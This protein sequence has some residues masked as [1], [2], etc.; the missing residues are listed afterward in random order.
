[1]YF[2]S[3]IYL[4][5]INVVTFFRFVSSARQENI[6]PFNTHD[7]VL[8]YYVKKIGFVVFVKCNKSSSRCIKI[9]R[10]GLITLGTN[11]SVYP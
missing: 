9:F 10:Q 3:L 7:A 8:I 11:L 2:V 4:S 5:K 1:M 6:I